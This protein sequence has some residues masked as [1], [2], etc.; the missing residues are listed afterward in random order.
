MRGLDISSQIR[1]DALEMKGFIQALPGDQVKR[2]TLWSLPGG[3]EP[4]PPALRL[5][6]LILWSPRSPVLQA[7][8][9]QVL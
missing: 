4:P 2:Q 3:V 8:L 9:H 1:R 5:F 6:S 7:F